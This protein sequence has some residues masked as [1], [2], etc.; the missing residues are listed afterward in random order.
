ML[1]QKLSTS[2]YT[3]IAYCNNNITMPAQG[4]YHYMFPALHHCISQDSAMPKKITRPE[5]VLHHRCVV[6]MHLHPQL[7]M[8]HYDNETLQPPYRSFNS[9]LKPH[10]TIS[11]FHRIE[12]PLHSQYTAGNLKQN[13]AKLMYVLAS[14]YMP[15]K[16]YMVYV[17]IVSVCQYACTS[18]KFH[19][20]RP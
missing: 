3:L 1:T 17:G 14:F 19:S 12:N 7:N 10:K 8:L 6:T 9:Y 5:Q 2:Y 20:S 15:I 13:A 4:T 16:R 11:L 18:V